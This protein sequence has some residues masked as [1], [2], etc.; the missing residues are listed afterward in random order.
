MAYRNNKA[1]ILI[2]FKQV[3]IKSIEDI[4]KSLDNE[5]INL[6][7]AIESL[8][9]KPSFINRFNV[10]NKEID[11]INQ[12]ILSFR[13]KI[14]TLQE[15]KVTPKDLD[16]VRKEFF[17]ITKL[18]GN[19][20]NDY[21]IL[22]QT[23][24][25]TE[26]G[27]KA[28]IQANLEN[29]KT[30]TRS[31]VLIKDLENEYKN[32]LAIKEKEQKIG[33]LVL[34]NKALEDRINALNFYKTKLKEI[35][36]F[37][38]D[39]NLEKELVK[40]LDSF[41]KAIQN[42][43]YP[44][45]KLNERLNEL[46]KEYQTFSALVEKRKNLMSSLFDLRVLGKSEEEIKK[47]KQK[48]DELF[49]EGIKLKDANIFNKLETELEKFKIEAQKAFSNAQK[50]SNL[51]LQALENIHKASRLPFIDSNK[52]AQYGNEIKK[53][54][55]L[56][57]KTG[58]SQPLALLNKEI[59][60]LV[61]NSLGLVKAYDTF[62]RL[63]NELKQL[64]VNEI[65]LRKLEQDFEK[66]A[67]ESKS[68]GKTTYLGLLLKDMRELKRETKNLSE[69]EKRLK[70]LKET[71]NVLSGYG[72]PRDVVKDLINEFKALSNEVKK[73]GD[74]SALKDF[75][76]R[77]NAIV[78]SSKNL[79]EVLFS[80]RNA[81]DKFMNSIKKA[82]FQ[83]IKLFDGLYKDANKFIKEIERI[84]NRYMKI[85]Q[86][87]QIQIS[88]RKG[89]AN[90]KDIKEAQKLIE[91]Y[92][93]KL[94]ELSKAQD[95]LKISLK[96][97]IFNTNIFGNI[98][99]SADE[100]IRQLNK[101]DLSLAKI[102]AKL[103]ETSFT[104]FVKHITK[105]ALG[106]SALYM[107]IYE[108]INVIQRGFG[109]IVQM[110]E[111]V[112]KMS[113]V[114]GIS[115]N[116]AKQLEERLVRLG[117]AYG[118]DIKAINEIAMALGRAGIESDKLVEVTEYVIKMSKLTGDQFETTAN[119]LITYIHNYN[120]AGVSIKQLADELTYVANASK[121]S[122]E[123]I[124]VFSNYALA[125]AKSANITRHFI[126]ALAIAFSNAGFEAST[127]GTSIRRLGTILQD[128]SNAV[129]QFFR[130]LG[131]NQQLFAQQVSKSAEDSE[132]M[133]VWLVKRLKNMSNQ[134]FQEAVGGMEV[135]ARQTLSAIR[136]NADS[137]LEQLRI[138][139]EG[140]SGELD[141]ANIMLDTYIG[142][143]ERLKNSLGL[144]F[145]GLMQNALPILENIVNKTI[146]WLNAINNALPQIQRDLSNIWMI[147]KSISAIVAGWYAFKG[148]RFLK[149]ALAGASIAGLGFLGIIKKIGSALE[150]IVTLIVR[151]PFVALAVGAV[152]IFTKLFFTI[153]NVNEELAKTNGL[154]AQQQKLNNL[155]SHYDMLIAKKQQLKKQLAE[156]L[157][158][159]D[160]E[161][162]KQLTYQLNKIEKQLETYKRIIKNQEEIVK[163]KQEEIDKAQ[164]YVE[165][166]LLS[167]K[168]ERLK[169]EYLK[170]NSKELEK[171]IKSIELQL[172]KLKEFSNYKPKNNMSKPVS[173]FAPYKE[174]V[175]NVANFKG[176][177]TWVENLKTGVTESEKLNKEIEKL[178]KSFNL[179]KLDTNPIEDLD[180]KLKAFKKEFMSNV[181][182]MKNET[183]EG[184]IKIV[185]NEEVSRFNQLAEKIRFF[186]NQGLDVEDLVKNLTAQIDESFKSTIRGLIK[187]MDISFKQAKI[188]IDVLPEGIGE[189]LKKFRI[190]LANATNPK[191]V[192]KLEAEFMKLK[193]LIDKFKDSLDK[194]TYKALKA[195]LEGLDKDFSNLEGLL[196]AK[197]SALNAI[198]PKLSQKPLPVK[199]QDYQIKNIFNLKDFGDIENEITKLTNAYAKLIQDTKNVEK[200]GRLPI[201]N[202]LIEVQKEIKR[203]D[204]LYKQFSSERIKKEQE[205][206]E[207]IDK[208]KSLIKTGYKNEEQRTKLLNKKKQLESEIK[209]LYQK[210]ESYKKKTLQAEIKEMQ[211]K[212]KLLV[213]ERQLNEEAKALNDK[214][215]AFKLEILNKMYE[216][217]KKLQ[218]V[219]F[220]IENDKRKIDAYFNY[221]SAYIKNKQ[222]ELD[223]IKETINTN[224]FSGMNIDSFTSSFIGAYKNYQ[225]QLD[226]INEYYDKQKAL[227]LAKEQELQQAKEAGKISEVEYVRQMEQLKTDIIR[228][229]I[230]RRKQLELN[231]L[232]TSLNMMNSY[233]GMFGNALDQLM[234]QGLIKQKRWLAVYKAI[235]VAQA[236]IDT[237]ASAQKAM[238]ELPYPLNIV[239]ASLAIATGMARVAIIKAQRYHTGGYVDRQT[240][241]KKMGGLKD[242]EIPAIL[243]KGEYVL[244][245]EEVKAI[246][247]SG[248]TTPQVNVTAPTPEI[249]IL[250]S[251]DPQ[252]FEEYLTSRSGR[253]IIKNIVGR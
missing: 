248:N 78:V 174:E 17:D 204:D 213:I 217:Q 224:Q 91:Q 177:V 242:D 69:V 111:A 86:N 237:Y 68:L 169:A 234:Q 24:G 105:M 241:N 196:K 33:N 9:L 46:E 141:K 122:T 156:A 211:I 132:R 127:I 115:A 45:D 124:N 146:E 162:V 223:K 140:V 210:E 159:N 222:V 84:R 109:F 90:E 73:T 14:K 134:E 2:E 189:E 219:N 150:F 36:D 81:F 42:A 133:M 175:P 244:S 101:L 235:R 3:G 139:N 8:E 66:L 89:F 195:Y 47:L 35:K 246:K 55:D 4:I 113:A 157:V 233:F 131:I 167:A 31:K 165:Y 206:Y 209:S 182:E 163:Q 12:K 225:Q 220:D 228:T 171:Q 26:K 240:A 170:T 208:I 77:L 83:E 41:R 147:I 148:L 79:R 72:V 52:I 64:G 123:D 236:I 120:K 251:V 250:N 56:A 106:Y 153:K 21:N 62:E 107:S 85:I 161:R 53:L 173:V 92:I 108:V 202:E 186:V 190:M 144:A 187:S 249:V 215:F 130:S 229:E 19:V 74:V 6:K 30:Y 22:K 16:R 200:T 191:D 100:S 39:S 37:K 63:K 243:Q 232:N 149:E 58:N 34:F 59:K 179:L 197:M 121:L 5:L 252:A 61:N 71:L 238:V 112:G 135:L 193:L 194:N 57:V 160:K 65:V 98:K 178:N 227:I 137:I 214:G 126:E 28:L 1:E 138:L 145:N 94:E 198:Y 152:T 180:R 142:K 104:K 75:E 49:K 125:T 95:Q 103:Q 76:K 158:D 23:I 40:P 192:V 201:V 247:E 87:L 50:Y 97:G 245:K 185:T 118:G 43:K 60:Q 166:Q 88:S 226:L 155:I 181:K 38:L 203:A 67:K 239:G 32:L 7:K 183:K 99:K 253:E 205:Y 102:K 143:W 54:Y 119:A 231:S 18:V 48:I 216:T 128:N 29:L 207:I 151:N 51:Y 13:N 15:V 80:D 230:E 25:Q 10:L 11:K 70:I 117:I 154:L 82:N 172:E 136:N 20:V 129:R 212:Q 188:D 93:K 176:N 110:N 168:L 44:I 96:T 218:I 221:I 27:I 199:F 114:F 184:L 116:K 164:K